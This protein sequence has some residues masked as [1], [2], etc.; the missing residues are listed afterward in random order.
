MK[1]KEES[2]ELQRIRI[3]VGGKWQ[4]VMSAKTQTHN[5][6]GTGEKSGA[7]QTDLAGA[8]MR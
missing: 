5:V 4:G 3:A 8:F 1:N 7:F 2:C 6:H